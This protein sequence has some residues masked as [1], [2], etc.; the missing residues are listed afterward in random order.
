VETRSYSETGAATT[1]KSVARIRI[2][3]IENPS[4]CVM[5]N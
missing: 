4:A 3:K 2:V 5:V 1:R